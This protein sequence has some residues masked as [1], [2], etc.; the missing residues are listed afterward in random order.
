MTVT[1][2]EM[3]RYGSND[4][5]PS[6][7]KNWVYLI[8][9]EVRFGTNAGIYEFDASSNRFL[10]DPRFRNYS[11]LLDLSIAS[12]KTIQ[13]N[14]GFTQNLETGFEELIALKRRGQQSSF[15]LIRKHLA[16]SLANALKVC[17]KSLA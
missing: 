1:I 8:D 17:K 12:T 13:I 7:N 5:L 10:P 16:R 2:S 11:N 3:A 9:N 14:Y 15:Q 6:Q 4:G